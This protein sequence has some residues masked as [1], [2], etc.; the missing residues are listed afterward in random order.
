LD[1]FNYTIAFAELNAK[2]ATLAANLYALAKKEGE[3]VYLV[4]SLVP[5]RLKEGNL[6][7][8]L[9]KKLGN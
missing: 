2:S 4:Q 6:A 5:L 8:E 1:L 7:K 9:L 3:V